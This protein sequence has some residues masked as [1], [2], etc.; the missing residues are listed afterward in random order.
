MMDV[1]ARIHFEVYKILN[2]FVEFLSSE[3]HC[4]SGAVYG[5]TSNHVVPGL[6]Q[7]FLQGSMHHEASLGAFLSWLLVESPGLQILYLSWP[8]FGAPSL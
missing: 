5:I 1:G 2:F 7:T 4:E 3:E 6:C 8:L